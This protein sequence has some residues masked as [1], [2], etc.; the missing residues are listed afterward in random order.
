MARHTIGQPEGGDGEDQPTL[1]A[2]QQG[3]I[4]YVPK[5]HKVVSDSWIRNRIISAV[6][7]T[8]FVVNII[9]WVT[10]RE[11]N[12]VLIGAGV[13]LLLGVPLINRGDKRGD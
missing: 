7:I 10:T 8:C 12:A 2:P 1:V 4:E 13:S 5:G 11:V 6:A 3:H 9:T